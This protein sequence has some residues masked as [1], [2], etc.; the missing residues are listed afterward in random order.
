M[1]STNGD[2]AVYLMFA[3]AR[4]ASIIRKGV[5]KVWKHLVERTVKAFMTFVVQISLITR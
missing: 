1:L 5:E 2:T 4:V 3:F